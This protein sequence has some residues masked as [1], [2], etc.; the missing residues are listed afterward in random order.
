[1]WDSSRWSRL[2]LT[3]STPKRRQD[4]NI[5]IFWKISNLIFNMKTKRSLNLNRAR[6]SSIPLKVA[7]KL[8]L[9]KTVNPANS[10]CFSSATPM[11]TTSSSIL[12]LWSINFDYNMSNSIK[13]RNDI[14]GLLSNI[15]VNL[16]E[17][18]KS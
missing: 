5:P 14:A 3:F 2:I 10:T 1:M 7:S 17:L 9:K 11:T 6:I 15:S 4:K 8:V 12:T 16:A 13:K 18:T